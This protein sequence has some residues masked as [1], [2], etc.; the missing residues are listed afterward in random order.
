[1]A[2]KTGICT[3]VTS[4]TKKGRRHHSV[5]ALHA[6]LQ[7]TLMCLPNM[8]P[9][10]ICIGKCTPA[11]QQSSCGLPLRIPHFALRTSSGCLLST[12]S[13]RPRAPPRLFLGILKPSLHNVPLKLESS[14][15]KLR[16]SPP[17]LR[18]LQLKPRE[19]QPKPRDSPLGKE[20]VPSRALRRVRWSDLPG[21]WLLGAGSLRVRLPAEAGRIP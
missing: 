16:A 9:A 12:R 14:Q 8:T 2:G 20:K 17:K 1:M 19:L 21:A 10:D 13:A 18:D 3:S 4:P 11:A 7:H 6:V 5:P 15:L